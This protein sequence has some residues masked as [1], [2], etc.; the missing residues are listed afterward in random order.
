MAD[1]M[2]DLQK[3]LENPNTP[4]LVDPETGLPGISL[5]KKEVEKLMGQKLSPTPAPEKEQP[6]M[7]L[8]PGFEKPVSEIKRSD[9]LFDWNREM[10]KTKLLGDQAGTEQLAQSLQNYKERPLGVDWKPMAAY[11]DTMIQGGGKLADSMPQVATQ[12]ERDI[13]VQQLEN[14]L[15]QRKEKTT[16]NMLA[17]IKEEMAKRNADIN[18]RSQ[19]FQSRQDVSKTN[20]I[21]NDFDKNLQKPLNTYLQGIA[22]VEEAINRNNYDEARTMISAYARQIGQERGAMSEGDVGRAFPKS[23][24]QAVTDISQWV[25]AN[26]NQ[27]IPARL[28]NALMAGIEDSKKSMGKIFDSYVQ[29]KEKTYKSS[30]TY[31]DYFEPGNVGHT[32]VQEAKNKITSFMQPKQE[33][34][35]ADL[36]DLALQEIERRKKGG[37]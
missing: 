32:S 28:R 8:P 11:L 25:S 10:L 30:P 14:M 35:P 36:K 20:Y 27:P 18:L 22:A 15:Q 12:E 37:K 2:F 5:P 31:K 26:K 9:D 3:V 24:E 29:T 6:K 16:E 4:I 23:L 1:K 33:Q 21:M 34:A 7:I 17:L 13:K 19:M